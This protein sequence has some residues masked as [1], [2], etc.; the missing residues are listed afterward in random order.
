[1]ITREGK[2]NMRYSKK[3]A[4]VTAFAVGFTLAVAACGGDD[5]GGGSSDELADT[6]LTVGSKEFT[7]QV[8]L[9]QIAILALAAAG[10]TVKDETGIEGTANVRKALDS[11]EIDMY[12]E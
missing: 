7:E 11:G 3:A 4:R 6:S 12:W 8:I 2:A 9:G 5:G 10:A 1:M